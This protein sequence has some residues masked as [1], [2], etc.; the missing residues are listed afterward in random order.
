MSGQ[1]K[2]CSSSNDES[3]EG[4]GRSTELGDWSMDDTS[5]EDDTVNAS[6]NDIDH[7]D[8]EIVE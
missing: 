1:D 2:E 3:S 6:K 5:D 4:E 7:L 8:N